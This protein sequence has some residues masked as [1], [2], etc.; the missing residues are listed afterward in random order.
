MTKTNKMPKF[1]NV[2]EEAEFWDSHDITDYIHEL[3]PFKLVYETGG[4][5]KEIVTIRVASALKKELTKVANLYD[6][7]PSSLIRMWVVE[8]LRDANRPC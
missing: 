5:R 7:S 8:K 2:K 6:I 1:N 3:A 4:E